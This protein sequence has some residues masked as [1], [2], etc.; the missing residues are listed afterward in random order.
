MEKKTGGMGNLISYTSR[1]GEVPCGDSDFYAF[2]TDMRNFRNVLPGGV[3]TE[4][5][6]TEDNCS[7]KVENTGRVKASLEEAL[8]H[9]V[10]SY[11]AETLFT[12]KISVQVFIEYISKNRSSFYITA[13]INM[14]PFIK[15]L[16]GD[17]AGSYLDRVVD[18][19]EAYGGFDSI[20]GCSQSL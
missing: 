19:V 13:G 3:L 11:N 17:S 20:R 5:E 12:G 15:M 6:A 7:F 10:I 2:L 1:K 18:A 16:V 4:W 14:N 9:S 8:P